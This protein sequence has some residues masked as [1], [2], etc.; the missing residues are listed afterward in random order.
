MCPA[1]V[2]ALDNC[3]LRIL[4]NADKDAKGMIP[5]LSQGSRVKGLNLRVKEMT[6]THQQP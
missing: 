3:I 5:G 1:Y 2:T 6:N 4:G